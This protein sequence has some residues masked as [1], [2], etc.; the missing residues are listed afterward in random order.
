MSV[1]GRTGA[2]S[3][4][5]CLPVRRAG[6]FTLNVYPEPFTPAG[7]GAKGPGQSGA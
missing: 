5:P 3:R 4:L 6:T 1:A 2:G 7:V